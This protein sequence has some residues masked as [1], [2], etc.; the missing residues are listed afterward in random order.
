MNIVFKETVQVVYVY[1]YLMR[2][3][4]TLYMSCPTAFDDLPICTQFIFQ[5]NFIDN[6]VKRGNQHNFHITFDFDGL[7]VID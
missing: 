1:S 2:C 5:T 4:C 7:M 6:L 3:T